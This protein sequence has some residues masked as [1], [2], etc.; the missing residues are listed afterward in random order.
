MERRH[1]IKYTAGIVAGLALPVNLSCE[2]K[3]MDFKISLA[4]W[5]LH[6]MLYSGE[7]DHLEFCAITK[8]KFNLDA[9]EYVNSF[10]FDK[11]RDLDYLKEMKTRAD[12]QGVASLLIMCDN[13]GHLGDPNMKARETAVENHYKW[14][15]AARFLGCHSIR[16]NAQS[17]G[18]YEEQ[19]KLA[20]DGL[21]EIYVSN[22]YLLGKFL[23]KE[24]KIGDEEFKIGTEINETIIEKFI[25]SKILSQ[26]SILA[27]RDI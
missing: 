19:I 6:R 8:E 12:D 13:E 4:E 16:V 22:Q 20:S 27:C 14:A 1:F 26:K 11:A 7:L 25:D 18:S 2:K 5:S 10:F 23:I 9:V 17:S 3:K 21:K 15:E 24:I